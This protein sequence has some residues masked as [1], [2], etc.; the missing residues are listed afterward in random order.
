MLSTM[1]NPNKYSHQFIQQIADLKKANANP[2]DIKDK[3]GTLSKLDIQ[4]WR[5]KL[6][7]T[8]DGTQKRSP[9]KEYYT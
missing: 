9:E 8:A 4:K 2:T 6:N 3:A 7:A 1:S 5:N